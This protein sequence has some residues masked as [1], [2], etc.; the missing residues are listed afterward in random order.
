MRESLKIELKKGNISRVLNRV[1]AHLNH[2]TQHQ[3]FRRR[4]CVVMSKNK[5]DTNNGQEATQRAEFV[6]V[7]DK[8]H[9]MRD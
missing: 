6:P 8:I 7:K 2:R 9:R 3:I 1:L 5:I 4:I